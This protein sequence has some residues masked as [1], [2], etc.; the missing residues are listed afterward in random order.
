MKRLQIDMNNTKNKRKCQNILN[1][2]WG[3]PV[4]MLKKSLKTEEML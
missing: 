1:K 3:I 4:K 2:V